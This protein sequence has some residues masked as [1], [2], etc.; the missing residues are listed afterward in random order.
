MGAGAGFC[1]APHREPVAGKL[2]NFI[3]SLKKFYYFL[4][5]SCIF[6]SDYK[7]FLLDRVSPYNIF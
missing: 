1:P 7:V 3:A 5:V 4:T 6:I 2:Y